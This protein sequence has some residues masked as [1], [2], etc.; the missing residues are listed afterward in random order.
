M[1][2]FKPISQGIIDQ[3]GKW[4]HILINLPEKL[5]S[6]RRNMQQRNIKQI[7]GHMIDSA[8]N[9][10][11][12]FVHLQ[13]QDSPLTYPNYAT[14]GKNDRWIA[15]QNYEQVDWQQLIQTWKYANKLVAHVIDHIDGS[16]LD[17]LWDTSDG[18]M[19]SLKDM[20]TDY[21]RH[22]K[23]HLKEIDE[24]IQAD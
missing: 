1:N 18:N 22:L 23:L 19:V 8:S 7:V 21:L 2:E 24:L 6:T 11:H 9:N 13:Y 20:I 15:I 4:E 16:K 17:N 14:H 12:R 10:R 5:V 3:V